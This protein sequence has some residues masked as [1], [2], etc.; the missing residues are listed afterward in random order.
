[1]GHEVAVIYFKNGCS[2]HLLSPADV[3]SLVGI[4]LQ[5]QIVTGIVLAMHLCAISIEETRPGLALA[6]TVGQMGLIAPV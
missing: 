3:G 2:R 6:V 1:M 5:V 4:G